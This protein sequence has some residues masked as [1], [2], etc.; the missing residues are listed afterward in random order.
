MNRCMLFTH[1]ILG[2]FLWALGNKKVCHR[3]IKCLKP[4][5]DTFEFIGV[6]FESRIFKLIFILSFYL[7][8]IFTNSTPLKRSGLVGPVFPL[9]ASRREKDLK[10]GTQEQA[11][12]MYVWYSEL[13]LMNQ[14]MLFLLHLT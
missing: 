9:R 10:S 1:I 8:H 14:T 3:T 6:S 5:R 2:H 4:Y 11:F 13:S 7:F 12:H